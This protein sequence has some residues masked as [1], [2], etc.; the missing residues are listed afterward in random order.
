LSDVSAQ[1]TG[2]IPAQSA[3]G[4]EPSVPEPRFRSFEV[5]AGAGGQA[6]GL[7]EAGFDPVL[8]IDSKADACFTIDLNRPD[9][10]VVCMDVV[11]FHP[12]MRPDTVGVD[13]IS[14][15]LPR[16]R[17]GASTGR[18][19]DS[20]QRAVLRAVIALT[21]DIRPK[22]LLLE[23]VPDIVAGPDFHTDRTWIEEELRGA[24]Y[25]MD[26]HVLNA[27]D[28]GVPQNRSSGFLVALQEPYFARFSWPAPEERPSP[29]VGQVL[30]A[31]WPLTDGA[32]R[33][34]GS[35]VRTARPLPW[36]A[37][38]SAEVART[39]ARPGAR[40]HGPRSG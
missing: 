35:R 6:L 22:A 34:V 26:W 4:P 14:G 9:W 7:E 25:L 33:S 15:G 5:C 17:S 39:W 21:R 2:L 24:G 1:T 37:G 12:S 19:D 40:R 13:L 28:F 16:V 11:Q 18:V 38:P 30:G 32:G 3:S 23:N 8:L 20:E 29:T 31:P 27:A 10:D 36:S